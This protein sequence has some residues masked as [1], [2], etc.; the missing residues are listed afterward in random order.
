MYLV[1]SLEKS[2]CNSVDSLILCKESLKLYYECLE[3]IFPDDDPEYNE[4]ERAIINE[5]KDCV[6]SSIDKINK[7][8]YL[9][10][11]CI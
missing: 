7:S 4:S 10:Q 8:V 6:C 11:N 5:C 9:L 1:D 2:Y 3:E